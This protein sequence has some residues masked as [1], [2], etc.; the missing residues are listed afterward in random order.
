[1]EQP[2]ILFLPFP[3]TVNSYWSHSKR[4]VY[5]SRK[6]RIY[7]ETVA[8]VIHEQAASLRLD[9]R[10]HVEV[11]LFMPDN[12]QRDLD[13]YMK[14]LLDSL[15]KAKLWFDDDQIDQLHIYRGKIVKRGAVL[16]EI[17]EAGPVL[18]PPG[19]LRIY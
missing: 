8:E 14:A 13:N 3:P 1:M 10:L 6:G 9:E 12:R 7:S 17:N 2:L 4:G 19:Q 11:T 18:P 15:T 5:L 16:I